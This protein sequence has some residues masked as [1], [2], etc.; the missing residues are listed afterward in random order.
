MLGVASRTVNRTLSFLLF[1][2][3]LFHA[4]ATEPKPTA[5][6]IL[7]YHGGELNQ[8]PHY[9]RYLRL[10]VQ[11]RDDG[12]KQIFRFT[13]AEGFIGAGAEDHCSILRDLLRY[14]GDRDYSRV[15]AAESPQIRSAVIDALDY[16][17]PHPGWKPT[18]YPVT[19]RLAK[20]NTSY[21][22]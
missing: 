14:W 4:N 3:A 22:Q 19:Y 10:A 11:M 8:F 16:T 18:E 7:Q 21:R 5:K 15:L 2:F 6:T 9:E 17:W 1:S 20:H 13:V 12:L